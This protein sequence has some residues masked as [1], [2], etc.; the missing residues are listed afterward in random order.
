[1]ENGFLLNLWNLE[2][3]LE[4]RNHR[5]KAFGIDEKY[6]Y[7][8]YCK[9]WKSIQMFPPALC[10]PYFKCMHAVYTITKARIVW[11]HHKLSN[12]VYFLYNCLLP[13]WWTWSLK[14]QTSVNTLFASLKHAFTKLNFNIVEVNT[15]K[16]LC[17]Y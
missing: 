16:L 9:F 17:W 8:S 7:E 6:F 15:A 4:K 3:E 1:M 13:F 10:S 5:K 12:C 14:K 2:L 11:L